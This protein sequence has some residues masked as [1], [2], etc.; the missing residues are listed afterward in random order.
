MDTQKN[1]ANISEKLPEWI[2]T[3]YVICLAV[4]YVLVS[5]RRFFN[6]DEFQV[7][8]ASAAILRKGALYKE[9]IGTHFPL[10]NLI[11]CVPSQLLGFESAVLI[12]SRYLILALNGIMLLYTYRIG[13]LLWGRK[14]GL[15]SVCMILS[16]FVF[17]EKGIE[18]RHD[19]FN[20]VF[21]VM[22]A[23][24]GIT[25]LSRMR[26]LHLLFSTLCFGMALASTQKAIVLAGGFVI[27]VLMYLALHEECRKSFGRV[28]LAYLLLT[29]IPLVMC[30]LVL[31]GAGNDTLADFWH[32]A[33]KGIIIGFSPHTDSLYPFPYERV[34]LFKTLF[35]SNPFFYVVCIGG[36][37][38]ILLSKRERRGK[39]M[40]IGV[41]AAVG[42][43]FY[44]TSKRPFFQTFLAVIPPLAIIGGGVLSSVWEDTLGKWKPMPRNIAVIICFFFLFALP[45]PSILARVGID[46][47]FET[48]LV[49][50]S[51]CVENLKK[52]DRVL[53]F[54]QNQ[55]FF[56]PLM[57]MSDEECGERIYDYNA[58]CVEKK[59]IQAQCRVI[60]ND[61]RTQL[62]N[63]EI[64]RRIAENYIE[65]KSGDI[66]I[67]GFHIP[68]RGV[69]SKYIWI[70]GS[71][72][73]PTQSL[74]IDGE[75]LDE[76]IIALEQELHTFRNTTDRPVALVYIFDPASLKKH[77]ESS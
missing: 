63:Q 27:G 30:L 32:Y 55:I 45:V 37:I 2:L 34:D 72:Y 48:A 4:G 16:S 58:D 57:N 15:L 1:E 40:I 62:L 73:S 42:L 52:D 54:T 18:I 22:G 26:P 64:K 59:M 10:A 77:L 60:I 21:S 11:M 50:T 71:Y 35:A 74:E 7:V 46:K 5:G 3:V 53:C 61:Y 75:K 47:R 67:P 66:F 28:A 33:V 29:P 41:W 68:P 17:L 65:A 25:Y 69:I 76:N 39:R 49:N 9:Q 19:V 38:L 43:A 23:Y 6:F 14:A 51:F 70:K 36:V 56:D 13:F 44:V 8:Y 12:V 31:V 20:T 24:Y